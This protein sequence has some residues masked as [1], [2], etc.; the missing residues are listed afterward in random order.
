MTHFKLHGLE[1]SLYLPYKE[2]L[3]V[4][5]PIQAS[6]CRVPGDDSALPAINS[7]HRNELY[8]VLVEVCEK[9][10]GCRHVEGEDMTS[11]WRH[12]RKQVG[13][14]MWREKI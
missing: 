8:Y 1:Q 11:W 12:V 6:V 9:A 14:G 10:G 3:P 7:V 5:M 13:A 4:D 2:C